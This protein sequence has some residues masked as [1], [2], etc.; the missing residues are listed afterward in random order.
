MV[1]E[2]CLRLCELCVWVIYL[3]G[4]KFLES[5]FGQNF[6]QPFAEIS[7]GFWP[8][9]SAS[10]LGEFSEAVLGVIF[11]CEGEVGELFKYI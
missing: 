2:V 11:G 1:E 5:D 10:I 7:G 6:W 3:W 8:K 9:C 4:W